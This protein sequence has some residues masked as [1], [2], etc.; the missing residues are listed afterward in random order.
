MYFSTCIQLSALEMSTLTDSSSHSSSSRVLSVNQHIWCRTSQCRSINFRPTPLIL[1]SLPL[2]GQWR[3]L[4]CSHTAPAFQ[5]WFHRMREL[6]CMQ[7][8][9][10]SEDQR[11]CW[12][13]WYFPP[14]S[15]RWKHFIAGSLD[16]RD[17]DAEQQTSEFQQWRQQVD[18]SSCGHPIG[19]RLWS[20]IIGPPPLFRGRRATATTGNGGGCGRLVEISLRATNAARLIQR[21]Y[22]TMFELRNATSSR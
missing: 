18:G 6:F 22:H 14:A 1:E 20:W 2:I 11:T 7:A 5:R 4:H 19:S 17:H 15:P 3:L 10:A 8:V 21:H 9:T 16:W 12:H 13:V